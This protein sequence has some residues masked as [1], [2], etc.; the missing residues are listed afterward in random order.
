MK[1]KVRSKV[2][3][4]AGKRFVS[5]CCVLAMVMTL[6]QGAGSPDIFAVELEGAT[7]QVAVK[8]LDGIG[9]SGASVTLLSE[10]EQ[11]SVDT[12]EEGEGTIENV[13]VGTYDISVSAVG[14]ETYSSS[15]TIEEGE[16]EKEIQAE[17]SVKSL[18]IK[19]S[20]SD[21]CIINAPSSVLYDNS[22]EISITIEDGYELEEILVNGQDMA[23]SFQDGKFLLSHVK[24][25]QNIQVSCRRRSYTVTLSIG[26]NGVVTSGNETLGGEC[27]NPPWGQL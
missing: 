20:V 22:A 10:T 15:V 2:C 3:S 8:G 14:Y 6:L 24:E 25:D 17:L 18:N 23:S 9:I 16:T 1:G 4:I 5:L 13:A 27:H 26:E 19:T 7:V 21:G 12:G 11:Y